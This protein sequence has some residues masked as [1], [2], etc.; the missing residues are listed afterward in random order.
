M[1]FDL[2]GKMI[3]ILVFAG[4]MTMWTLFFQKNFE[5]WIISQGYPLGIGETY[6]GFILPSIITLIIAGYLTSRVRHEE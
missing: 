2:S 5:N 3:W 6:L 4:V 1:R